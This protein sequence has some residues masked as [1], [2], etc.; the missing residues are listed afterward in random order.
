MGSVPSRLPAASAGFQSSFIPNPDRKHS[1]GVRTRNPDRFLVG[2]DIDV[3]YAAHTDAKQESYLKRT[4]GVDRDRRRFQAAQGKA[5]RERGFR[6][7]K[8]PED[9]SRVD[10]KAA[11]ARRTRL[12]TH[13]EI[14]SKVDL[15][16]RTEIAGQVVSRPPNPAPWTRRSKNAKAKGNA[17]AFS[18]F[19]AVRQFRR[20]G[21]LPNVSVE[22]VRGAALEGVSEASRKQLIQQLLIRG[23]IEENPGPQGPAPTQ[24]SSQEKKELRR[25]PLSP[26]V[27]AKIAAQ[28]VRRSRKFKMA[29][30]KKRDAEVDKAIAKA[31]HDEDLANI[32]AV[33]ATSPSATAPAA[34]IQPAAVPAPAAVQPAAAQ[35]EAAE[36]VP[37]G[38]AAAPIP[39]APAAPAPLPVAPPAEPAAPVDPTIFQRGDLRGD[40]LL[41]NA[42][43]DERIEFGRSIFGGNVSV[44]AA[45][46][47]RFVPSGEERCANKR[48]VEEI[49]KPIEFRHIRYSLGI[50]KLHA[51]FGYLLTFGL[52][53]ASYFICDLPLVGDYLAVFCSASA[54][55]FY[56]T[57]LSVTQRRSYATI[58][59][60]LALKVACS[61]LPSYTPHALLIKQIVPQ[62]C[63]LTLPLLPH[64][65]RT[66]SYCPH[67]VACLLSEYKRGTDPEVMKSS[68]HQ[69][70]M[71]LAALPIP[72]RTIDWSSNT[73]E[74]GSQL[75]AQFLNKQVDFGRAPSAVLPGQ[76]D[77]GAQ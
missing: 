37:L 49:K 53:A 72:D 33:Y 2:G 19:R 57:Y 26:E 14:H 4:S 18:L 13:T 6:G 1:R 48:G 27:A 67:L 34:V 7:K 36:A 52:V 66:V 61:W 74:Y 73:V 68:I 12:R 17:P 35:Q 46:I 20:T 21:Q 54:L 3:E 8:V 5:F 30:F 40:A 62:L 38:P 50:T 64:G 39:A 51:F 58:I 10:F 45:T 31:N 24:L 56:S 77:S 59:G 69:K 32:A 41:V 60:Y 23:G 76:A 47:Q 65:Q 22:V 71:R 42:D 55:F 70:T 9:M 11:K 44:L 28:E 25:D 16:D 29:D 15:R 63:L 75:V 43:R